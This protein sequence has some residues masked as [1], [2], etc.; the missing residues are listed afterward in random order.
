MRCPA[1]ILNLC[2]AA[3]V[4]SGQP[5]NTGRVVRWKHI[6]SIMRSQARRIRALVSRGVSEATLITRSVR[7]VFG[8]TA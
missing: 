7:S 1:V 8:T 5:V 3:G 4:L 2:S 6:V